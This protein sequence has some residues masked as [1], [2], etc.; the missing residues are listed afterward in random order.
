MAIHLSHQRV[1]AYFEAMKEA[2]ADANADVK[3]K[4]ITTKTTNKT[5]PSET[6]INVPCSSVVRREK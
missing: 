6:E 5:P 3:T 4:T 2:D 1:V